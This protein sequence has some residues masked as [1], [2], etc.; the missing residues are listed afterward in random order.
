MTGLMDGKRGLIMGLA[1]D[2][3]LA[4]GIARKLREHGA[5][6]AFTYPN[7]AIEKRVR[8]LA[9]ELGSDFVFPCDVGDMAA[10]EAC[11]AVIVE[12]GKTGFGPSWKQSDIDALSV[13]HARK[14]ARVLRLKSGDPTVFGRLDE[15]IDACDAAGVA[16]SILPGLTSASAAAAALGQSLTRRGR[17]SELR[18]LTGH[19]VDGFADQ[20]WRALARPGAVA[21]IYMG[22]AAARFL[23]GRLLMHGGSPDTPVTVVE[24]AS[25]P[26]Q[27]LLPT[28]LGRLEPNLSRAGLTGPAL[29]ILGL[30]PR[31]AAASLTNALP[32]EAMQ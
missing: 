21:A 8:P 12:T 28:T 3:S 18:F 29:L 1:N 5:E 16:W 14:G 24:N 9:A 13:D 17:N 27:R 6:L 20:D 22:K 10:M 25:R 32:L 31:A 11:E 26:D 30:A 15:E 2:K 19:D 23:Q 7:A 4:W